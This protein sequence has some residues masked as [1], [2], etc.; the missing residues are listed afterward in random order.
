MHAVGFKD[1]TQKGVGQHSINQGFAPP[2]KARVSKL[3]ANMNIPVAQNKK[4]GLGAEPQTNGA[5]ILSAGADS[6]FDFSEIKGW[7]KT[8]G[9]KNNN[10]IK[11]LYNASAKQPNESVQ[12][13]R[14][15]VFRSHQV[16]FIGSVKGKDRVGAGR[17]DRKETVGRGRKPVGIAS[18]L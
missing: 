12:L 18:H 11:E 5:G 17:K 16:P 13:N 6:C 8:H 14:R 3:S 4:S 9:Q 1:I 10:S 15:T 2:Q 7:V